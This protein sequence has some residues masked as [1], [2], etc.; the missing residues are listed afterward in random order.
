M[1]LAK[2][3]NS[4]VEIFVQEIA[5]YNWIGSGGIRGIGE[6]GVGGGGGGER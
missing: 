6:S 1:T 3:L 4:S 2:G 5:E